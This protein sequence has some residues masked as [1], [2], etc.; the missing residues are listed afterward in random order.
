MKIKLLEDDSDVQQMRE[1]IKK[2]AAESTVMDFEEVIT[3]AS[4]RSRTRLWTDNDAMAAFAYVDDYSNLQFE[5]APEYRTP[6]LMQQIVDWGLA[7]VRKQN[8]SSGELGTLDAVFKPENRWQI[9]MLKQHGFQ[10]DQIRSLHYARDLTAPIIERPL[11]P[12]FKLRYVQGEAEVP[13]LVALHRAAFGTENMTP[14]AR[15]SIMRAPGYEPDLDLV[16]VAPDGQ[17]A[18]FCICGFEDEE[19]NIGYTDPIGT[20]PRDQRLGLGKAI[21]SSGLLALQARGAK[22]VK[23]GTS[24]ENIAMRRLAESLGFGVVSESIWFSRQVP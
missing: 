23:L 22:K 3:L 20:H 21:V 7:C 16:L 4:V 10:E 2:L 6:Q 5:V 17:L 15:L 11:P 14:E 19:K 8:E 18:A 9:E 24:S 1:L 13:A 12:G